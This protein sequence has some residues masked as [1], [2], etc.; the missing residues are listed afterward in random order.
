MKEFFKRAYLEVYDIPSFYMGWE[1]EFL[2]HLFSVF[3]IMALFL[4][5]A[6]LI[7]IMFFSKNREDKK[8]RKRNIEKMLLGVLEEKN[9]NKKEGN[10]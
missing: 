4:G 6:Y 7:K 5:C 2:C 3:F 9:K 8:K 1:N 10:I